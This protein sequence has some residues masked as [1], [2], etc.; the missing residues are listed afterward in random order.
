LKRISSSTR[1][2]LPKWFN[3]KFQKLFH[4]F[5]KW[6]CSGTD[7]SSSAMLLN[8]LTSDLLQHIPKWEEA[9]LTDVELKIAKWGGRFLIEECEEMMTTFEGNPLALWAVKGK[10]CM[11]LGFFLEDEIL[12]DWKILLDYH[13][14]HHSPKEVTNFT[15]NFLATQLNL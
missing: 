10:S 13:I 3:V 6:Q 4:L 9:C 5:D 14:T 2:A 11:N 15:G 12:Q 7:T 1:K 8:D